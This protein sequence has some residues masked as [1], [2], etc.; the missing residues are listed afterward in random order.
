MLKYEDSAEE[1]ARDERFAKPVRRKTGPR[2]T[3]PKTRAPKSRDPL[4]IDAKNFN[5]EIPDPDL[6]VPE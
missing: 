6:I 1:V 4:G 2:R 3:G 5:D